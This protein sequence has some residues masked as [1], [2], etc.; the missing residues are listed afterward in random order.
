[1]LYCLF[2]LTVAQKKLK[3]AP[4]EYTDTELSPIYLRASQAERERNERIKGNE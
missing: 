1:M 2:Q 3:E 4:T